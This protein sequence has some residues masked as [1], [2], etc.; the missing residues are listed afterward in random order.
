MSHAQLNPTVECIGQRVNRVP[1]KNTD[2]L[3]ELWP[4]IARKKNTQAF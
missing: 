2:N 3:L 4:I 1:I